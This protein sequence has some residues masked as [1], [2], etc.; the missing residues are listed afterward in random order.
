MAPESKNEGEGNRTAARAYNERAETH[1]RK[2]DVEAEAQDAKAAMDGDE[3]A[4]LESARE[5]A[6][7]RAHEF[8]PEERKDPH[9]PA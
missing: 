4:E 2:A 5:S 3:R 9:K 1:T 7:T 8:D 6:K